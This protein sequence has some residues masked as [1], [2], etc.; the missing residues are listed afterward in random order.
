MSSTRHKIEA[1]PI[2]QER[3][4]SSAEIERGLVASMVAKRL[5]V[6]DDP[7]KR[8]LIWHLHRLSHTRGLAVVANEIVALY[9]D[10]LGTKAM[11]FIQKTEGA[12]YTASEVRDVR[13]DLPRELKME[14]P[15]RGEVKASKRLTRQA[16]IANRLRVVREGG[17][18]SEI[19]SEIE[20]EKKASEN[21]PNSYSVAEFCAAC[22]EEAKHRFVE[23]ITQ[24]CLDPA[25][26]FESSA[27]WYFAKVI[28]ALKSYCDQLTHRR[29]KEIYTTA[30]GGKVHEI[31][32]LLQ[33]GERGMYTIEGAARI[34]KSFSA[35]AWCD[36]HPGE[37]RFIEVPTG[38]DDATFFRTLAR[39]LGIGNFTQYKANEVRDRVE[40][41]LLTRDLILCLDEGQRLWPET[42]SRHVYPKRIN[43]LTSMVNQGLRICVI[44][45]PQF[46]FRLSAAEQNG[47]W[48]A[49]QLLGRTFE[50]CTLANDLS[51]EDLKAVAKV[52]LPEADNDVLRALAAYART[53]AKYLAAIE[54]IVARARFNAK[55]AGRAK[56]TADDVRQA[57]KMG[58]IPADSNLVRVLEKIKKPSR[59]TES[60]TDKQ[61]LPRISTATLLQGNRT[62]IAAPRKVAPLP[63]SRTESP[64]KEIAV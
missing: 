36:L 54:A 27:P 61:E 16:L 43:W 1:G 11:N 14:F 10:R 63:S 6:V 2:R 62:S 23:W 3:F 47:G 57:M 56:T 30:L 25:C 34:G 48:N 4:A 31:L 55:R 37:A 20:H 26:D 44:V 64:L 53:S 52:H 9:G 13:A 41:V 38:N 17:D 39:G 7:E 42:G 33:S 29:A 49:A 58:V 21:Q 59:H 22:R 40:S 51:V 18:T 28:E 60:K 35:A 5:S 50:Y 15:L 12:S 32:D 46:L 19:D 45:T 8:K 24:L